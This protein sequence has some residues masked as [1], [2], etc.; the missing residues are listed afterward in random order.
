MDSSILP[1]YTVAQPFNLPNRP[2]RSLDVSGSARATPPTSQMPV[3]DKQYA[4]DGTGRLLEIEDEQIESPISSEFHHQ[5]VQPRVL[6][7]GANE[8]DVPSLSPLNLQSPDV[9]NFNIPIH[10]QNF[11]NHQHAGFP[12]HDSQANGSSYLCVA[13]DGEHSSHSSQ[14]AGPN[15]DRV[16]L[17]LHTN[18]NGADASNVQCFI[19]EGSC[20]D[21]CHCGDDGNCSCSS[22]ARHPDNQQVRRTVE[23][24]LDWQVNG[25]M[26][27]TPTESET[28]QCSE[29]S[30]RI[31]GSPERVVSDSPEDAQFTLSDSGSPSFPPR[32]QQQSGDYPPSNIDP[33]RLML[34]NYNFASLNRSHA[35]TP[36]QAAACHAANTAGMEQSWDA[37]GLPTNLPP[38]TAQG[39]SAG[40]APPRVTCSNVSASL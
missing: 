14:H 8:Q 25:T 21:P 23:S 9:T 16:R 26:P 36:V 11:Q 13:S 7:D 4:V 10:A 24:L 3:Y 27:N 30:P 19:P 28:F 6:A 22:C 37:F 15:F 35:P 33:Q 39:A 34:S 40:H 18:V 12:Q 29:P 31:L 17:R 20:E 38:H 32:M 2:F 1:Q 5:F